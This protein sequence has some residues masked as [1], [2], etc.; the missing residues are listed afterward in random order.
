MN[1]QLVFTI[2]SLLVISGCGW[3]KQ[4]NKE[5]KHHP[6]KT[7]EER[8]HH[9]VGVKTQAATPDIEAMKQKAR[10][11]KMEAKQKLLEKC[12]QSG[13]EAECAQLMKQDEPVKTQSREHGRKDK[14]FCEERTEDPRTKTRVLGRERKHRVC[15]HATEEKGE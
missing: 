7:S 12:K 2:S 8:K 6:H 13:K 9:G 15:K 11:K 14:S 3:G 1:Y 10:Q 4:E 5:H